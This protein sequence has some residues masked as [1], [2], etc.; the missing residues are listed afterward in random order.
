MEGI[1]YALL[2][3]WH[4]IYYIPPE[5]R[6]LI[7]QAQ[8]HEKCEG[9]KM[10]K[11]TVDTILQPEWIVPIEPHNTVLENHSIV[12]DQGRIVALL[13]RVEAENL[14]EA[15]THLRLADHIVMPG[16]MN[17]HAHSPMVLFRGMAD[18]LG[19]MDW[20]N[21]HIW[22]AETQW[23][24]EE[25]MRDGTELAILEMLRSGTT[26]FNENYFFGEVTAETAVIAGIR[27]VVGAEV[28]NLPTQYAGTMDEYLTKME[29]FCQ[30]WRGHPLIKPTIHPQGP[31]TV[32]D[33]DFLQV[34][35]FADEQELIIHT[36]LHETLDE[37]NGS[38]QQYHKRPVQRLYDLGLFSERL[39]CVHMCHVNEED[40]A[41]LQ[42]TRPQI[43]HSPESNLK[44]ASGFCPV[45]KIMTAG[46][47]VALGTDGAASN[48]DLDMFGEMRTAAIL[49]K[50]V[51]QDSTAL[52]AAEALQMA[53]LNGARAF[54]LE[55]EIGSIQPGKSADLIAIDLSAV[56]TQPIYHPISQLVY[57]V[58][59]RQVSDVWVAG[60]RLLKNGEFTTL[61]A[62]AILAKARKW[63]KKI[64]G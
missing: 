48:N 34:K 47:N 17:S 61:D 59:S 50:A 6:L 44:L 24:N 19:L 63:R 4:I 64:R 31:Y 43:V 36:H 8:K 27:A 13:P 7:M 39:V 60:Q 15:N 21:N 9:I 46:I 35:A 42:A 58:N 56:N 16:L 3:S 11:A 2:N 5:S 33:D 37:I 28:I 25:F 12:I 45:K 14:Y 55:R 52:N 57:A 32:S 26:C 22:P 10:R 40:L 41:I 1:G 49:A 23:M 20:L 54:G 53:T 18:D 51:A 29:I 38:I 62:E 30:Q